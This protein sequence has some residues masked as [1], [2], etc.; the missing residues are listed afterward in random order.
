[1]SGTY[2]PHEQ[3]EQEQFVQEYAKQMANRLLGKY[4]FVFGLVILMLA[5]FIW[6]FNERRFGYTADARFLSL[7]GLKILASE[8]IRKWLSDNLLDAEKL[9]NV[10]RVYCHTDRS[11]L[12]YMEL[13]I[14]VI[15]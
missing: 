7:N 11:L 6:F 9:T 10:L 4:L 3:R 2:K 1:M 8:I 5:S 15:C 12:K 14:L 13:T